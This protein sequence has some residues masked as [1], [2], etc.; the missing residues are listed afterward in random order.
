[1]F[2]YIIRFYIGETNLNGS[3]QNVTDD[4]DDWLRLREKPKLKWTKPLQHRFMS[5]LKSLGV[6]SKY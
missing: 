4:P 1:L 2:L 6:A 3:G 5:A